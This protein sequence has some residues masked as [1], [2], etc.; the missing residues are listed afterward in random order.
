MATRTQTLTP[1]TSEEEVLDARR[2]VPGAVVLPEAPSGPALAEAES[3]IR[4]IRSGTDEDPTALVD[5]L[6]RCLTDM[7][8]QGGPRAAADFL[9]RQLESAS[10]AQLEDRR[11]RS[12]RAAAVRALLALG[13]PYALE[14]SPEDLGYL[15]AEDARRGPWTGPAAGA[16][17]VAGAGANVILATLFPHLSEAG[18]LPLG[19]GSLLGGLLAA[20]TRPGSRW[21]AMGMGLLL[22]VMA[23]GVLFAAAGGTFEAVTA[24]ASLVALVLLI[25]RR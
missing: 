1:S 6:H 25:W 10:L 20:F 23:G 18:A 11:G 12:T 22:A 4:Q 8:A 5:R 15:R 16:V 21:H 9:L 14:V 2:P 3:L 24:L 19:L 13:Y 7:T 17:V